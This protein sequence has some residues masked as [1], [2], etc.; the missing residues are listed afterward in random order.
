MN[1]LAKRFLGKRLAT[2]MV[3]VATLLGGALGGSPV[4]AQD[5][6]ALDWVESEGELQDISLADGTVIISG[7]EYRVVPHARVRVRGADSSLAGLS[8]GMKVQFMFE[9]FEGLKARVAGVAEG[10]V[11]HELQQLPDNVELLLH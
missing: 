7:F 5:V 4:L 1:K 10:F 11:I 3:F 2:A 8:V 9:T 6:A